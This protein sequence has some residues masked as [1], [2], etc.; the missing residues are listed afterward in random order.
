VRDVPCKIGKCLSCNKIG[1][2]VRI[3]DLVLPKTTVGRKGPIVRILF[4]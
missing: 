4:Q 3:L 2:I 1:F